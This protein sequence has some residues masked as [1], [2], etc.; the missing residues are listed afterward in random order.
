MLASIT[1]L[2]E[3]GRSSRWSVTM[4][5]FALGAIA[6]GAA[7]GAALG[8]IGAAASSVAGWS[9]RQRL[10]ALGA[11]AISAVLLDA[12]PLRLPTT[13]RQVDERWLR[14]YR[15]WVYGGGFG[16]QLGAGMATIV[17]TAAVYAA[18]VAAA[19]TAS[20]GGGAVVGGAF[21][22]AR[23]APAL[24]AATVRSPGQLAALG[25]R[26]RRWDRPAR[27]VV[28]GLETALAA[29]AVAFAVTAATGGPA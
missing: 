24:A 3:R 8:G 22:F 12:L 19:L 11:V 20:P 16:L 28:M 6:G 2:G 9:A 27:A 25:V 5:A 17:V 10:V 29:A 26:L 14:R 13:H 1:P 15:G 7:L 4:S 18:F 21:G 23:A